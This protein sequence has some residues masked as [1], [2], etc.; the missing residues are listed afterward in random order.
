MA[1]AKVETPFGALGIATSARGVVEVNLLGPVLD[2]DPSAHSRTY[3]VR[4]QLFFA[5]SN[6]LVYQFDYT[7]PAQR[8]VIDMSELSL[9]HI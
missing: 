8:I 5:S 3:K 1:I 2:D 7:D 9:I 6:D 4:G